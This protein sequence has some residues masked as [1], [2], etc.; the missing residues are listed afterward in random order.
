VSAAARKQP[1]AASACV[2]GRTLRERAGQQQGMRILTGIMACFLLAL[3][4][5]R[6][7]HGAA[8]LILQ[9][10]WRVVAVPSFVDDPGLAP[11]RE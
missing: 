11:G 5:A 9:V 8:H 2:P 7:G 1:L 10:V 6:H 3:E 4:D